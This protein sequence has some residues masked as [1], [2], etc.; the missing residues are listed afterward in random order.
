MKY[1]YNSGADIA[2]HTRHPST[3]RN[4]NCTK[5]I[6]T[7]WRPSMIPSRSAAI[8]ATTPGIANNPSHGN[9]ATCNPARFCRRS[10]ARYSAIGSTKKQW[11]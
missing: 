8:H 4:S 7:S 10:H 1:K 3:T 6:A 2:H 11:L 5:L 9:G